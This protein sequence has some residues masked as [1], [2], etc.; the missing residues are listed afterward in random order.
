[1]K[2]KKLPLAV[3]FSVFV[4]TANNYVK[5]EENKINQLQDENV[6]SEKVI[7]SKVQVYAY[8]SLRGAYVTPE[9]NR[10]VQTRRNAIP[11]YESTTIQGKERVSVS[12]AEKAYIDNSFLENS[13]QSDIISNNGSTLELRSQFSDVPDDFWAKDTIDSLALSKVVSGYPDHTFKP[14]L[15]ILRSELTSII[16]QGLELQ[17]KANNSKDSFKDVSNKNWA[18]DSINTALNSGIVSGYPDKTFRAD[19]PAT[20]A[21]IFSAISKAIPENLTK[22]QQEKILSENQNMKNIPDW[23]K[24]YTAKVLNARLTQKI[25]ASQ[26]L[27]TETNV[28]RAEVASMILELRKNLGLEKQINNMVSER[29][30]IEVPPQKSLLKLKFENKVSSKHSSAGDKF[31][32]K[33]LNPVT[34]NEIFFPQG[35]TVKGEII[36]LS[37][38]SLPNKG[39]I[40]LKFTEISNK[41]QK[42]AF[43][44]HIEKIKVEKVKNPNII[45]R[46]IAMPFTLSGRIIGITGRSIGTTVNVAANSLE[47]INNNVGTA[48]L[49]LLSSKPAS[50]G[51]SLVNAGKAFGKGIYNIGRTEVTGTFGLI[52]DTADEALYVVKPNGSNASSIN[53]NEE[54][55]VSF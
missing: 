39:G 9:I 22:E 43:P 48:T 53:P 41:N 44:D 49:E 28:S 21:E 36:D 29:P 32:A 19:K 7:E 3:A 34:V 38:P 4:L 26:N 31:V 5:A 12:T 37:R 47:E 33:T 16:V 50:S 8:P 55:T 11:N 23:A 35:S 17:K 24:G 20:K 1:M 10:V 51:H 54:I 15:P 52:S 42:T 14:T 27:D 25:P 6:K 46:T 13:Q 30:K 2:F 45:A 40:K 18:K